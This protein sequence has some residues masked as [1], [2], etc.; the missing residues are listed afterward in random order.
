MTPRG[1]IFDSARLGGYYRYKPRKIAEL[2]KD[3][4]SQVS[5][6]RPKIHESVFVRLKSGSDRYAPIILPARYAV[7]KSD[8]SIVGGTVQNG[9]V[10]QG[11]DLESPTQSQAR[12]VKQRAGVE[13]GMGAPSSLFFGRC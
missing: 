1:P 3:D 5:I 12:A 8:G 10:N 7:V 9:Q 13:L 2:I 6:A 4:F 11:N